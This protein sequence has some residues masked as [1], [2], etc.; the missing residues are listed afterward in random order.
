MAIDLD[1]DLVPEALETLRL[2]N[3]DRTDMKTGVS[4]ANSILDRSKKYGKIPDAASVFVM[5]KDTF[6]GALSTLGTMFGIA[7]E[8]PPMRDVTPPKVEIEKPKE[9]DKGD[10]VDFMEERG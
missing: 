6:R 1:K 2:A 5:D 8:V 4:A 7:K 9:E 3:N 10:F